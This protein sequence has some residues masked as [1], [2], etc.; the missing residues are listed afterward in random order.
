MKSNKKAF[1]MYIVSKRKAKENVGPLLNGAGKL[2]TR[3]MEKNE[4]LGA[5]F[6]PQFSPIKLACQVSISQNRGQCLGALK[7]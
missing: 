3:N 7:S 1:F 5:F 2:L 4:V 6:W